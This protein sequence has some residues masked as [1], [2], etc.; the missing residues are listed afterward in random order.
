M[1]PVPTYSVRMRSDLDGSDHQCCGCCMQKIM[2]KLE[3]LPH[4]VRHQVKVEV[5]AP[6]L[7]HLL[8]RSQS[9]PLLF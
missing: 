3:F 4:R 5:R 8:G 9:W 7:V 1:C 6:S 2:D